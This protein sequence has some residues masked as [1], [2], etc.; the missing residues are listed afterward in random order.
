MIARNINYGN[1]GNHMDEGKVG[2]AVMATR[3]YAA[4]GLLL[5]VGVILLVALADQPVDDDQ[6]RRPGVAIIVFGVLGVLHIINLVQA[7]KLAEG[8]VQAKNTIRGVTIA[9]VVIGLVG[10]VLSWIVNVLGGVVVLVLLS[11]V[12][13]GTR[14]E[15]PAVA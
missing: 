14:A 2:T 6:K 12:G 8:D 1:E 7:G 15:P 4:A 3:I 13:A 10:L 5:T 11:K 9:L